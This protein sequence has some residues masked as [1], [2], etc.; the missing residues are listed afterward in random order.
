MG[1]V[2]VILRVEGGSREILVTFISPPGWFSAIEGRIVGKAKYTC[3][4]V[5]AEI[6]VGSIVVEAG[7]KKGGVDPV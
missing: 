5:G 1:D 4:S 7:R 2:E 6:L 3:Q